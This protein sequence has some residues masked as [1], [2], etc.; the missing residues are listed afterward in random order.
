MPSS[1]SGQTYVISAPG[2]TPGVG[3]RSENTQDFVRWA[4][5]W[6]N[7]SYISCND[8]PSLGGV[9]C[10]EVHATFFMR[11]FLTARPVHHLGGFC[12]AS[13]AAFTPL[14]KSLAGPM[15]Q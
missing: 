12:C 11:R 7:I 1:V 5:L 9:E 13:N 3:L 8:P 6:A 14:A 4:N 15:P 2:G 10:R